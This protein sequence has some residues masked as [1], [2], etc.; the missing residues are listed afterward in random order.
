MA[1]V[2]AGEFLLNMYAAVVESMRG[3]APGRTVN[4]F[5]AQSGERDQFDSVVYVNVLEHI[6]DHAAELLRIRAALRPGGH[7]FIFVPALQWL[8][9]RLDRQVGHF[10]RYHKAPLAKLIAGSGL[11]LVNL[12]YFDAAGVL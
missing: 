7:A 11:S 3:E 12:R 8:Y 4:S 9:S 1:S 10:R 5:F 2:V 6:E